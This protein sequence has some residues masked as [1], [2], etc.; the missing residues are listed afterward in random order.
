MPFQVAYVFKSPSGKQLDGV[1]M[2]CCKVLTTIAKPTLELYALSFDYLA[3]AT[4]CKFFIWSDIVNQDV[5]E[6]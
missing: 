3:T 6:T 2:Y 4:N 5:H 1:T